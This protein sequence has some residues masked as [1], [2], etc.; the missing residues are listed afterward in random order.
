[1]KKNICFISTSRADFSYIINLTNKISK[2]NN[3]NLDIILSGSHFSK[4][5]GNT[6]K[7]TLKNKKYRIQKIKFNFQKNDFKNLMNF[8][9]EIFKN[10][11]KIFFYKNH[12]RQEILPHNIKDLLVKI[13]TKY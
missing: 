13:N 7:D 10:L 4:S 12:K 2:I 5:F 3:F 9:S 11:N 6:F 1:M 8:S